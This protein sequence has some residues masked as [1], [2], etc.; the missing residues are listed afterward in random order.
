[1]TARGARSRVSPWRLGGLSLRALGRRV[2]D[3]LGRDEVPDRAAALSYYFL[4]ALFPMLLFLTTLLGLLPG[5]SLMGPLLDYVSRVLPGDSAALVR[6]TLGEVTRGASAG[7]LSVGALAALWAASSGMASIMSA[8]N[9]A[10][11]AADDRPW[12]KRRL[13]AVVLTI[14]F[15][16]FVLGGLLLLVFGEELGR[17]L[18]G[19]V[20]LGDAFTA[21]WEIARWPVAIAVALAG[22]GLIYYL[23]PAADHGW[24]WVTPGSAFA[25]AGW[26]LASRGLRFYVA[27]FANYN[28]TY[29]SISAGS[30]CSCC[31][32]TSLA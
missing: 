17:A 21:A 29:G 32:C 31:G 9:V 26:L 7:L 30:S 6:Q 16:L 18:A 11:E 2:Y 24:H 4:F 10:Y 19:W 8:L 14:A 1:M 13:I 25:L 3:E 20:G 15:A 12:W 23:A 28:A 27:S 5:P 22:I